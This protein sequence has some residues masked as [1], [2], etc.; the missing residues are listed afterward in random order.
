MRS[1]GGPDCSQN[2]VSRSGSE[3]STQVSLVIAPAWLEIR[4]SPSS[5]ATRVSPP[6]ITT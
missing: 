6:G 3:A 1:T 4:S 2:P 5:G